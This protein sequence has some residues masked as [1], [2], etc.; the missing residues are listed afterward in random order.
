MSVACL[1]PRLFCWYCFVTLLGDLYMILH[2]VM[3]P[4]AKPLKGLLW[5]VTK[6]GR[7]HLTDRKLLTEQSTLLSGLFF[8]LPLICVLKQSNCCHAWKGRW[9]LVQDSVFSLEEGGVEMCY[10]IIQSLYWMYV[11]RRS[12]PFDSPWYKI[13]Y[14]VLYERGCISARGN[15]RGHQQVERAAEN[16]HQAVGS[17]AAPWTHLCTWHFLKLSPSPSQTQIS[18]VPPHE[19]KLSR[20]PST[21]K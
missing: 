10:I 5:L 21:Q 6:S 9:D 20:S 13:L 1:L 2:T 8:F 14:C 15:S 12:F 18:F 3:L 19:Q 11:W 16:Q 17:G 4:P 7:E